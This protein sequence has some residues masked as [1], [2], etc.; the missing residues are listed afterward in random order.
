MRTV[1]YRDATIQLSRTY[2]DFHDYRDDPNNLPPTEV[3][4][5]A[6]LVRSAPIPSTFASRKEADDTFFRLMFPG[7]GLSM[8]QLHDPVALYS[9]EVPQTGEDRWVVLIEKN[10]RWVVVD[11]FLW[12]VSSGYLNQAT[13][14]NGRLTYFDRSGRMLREKK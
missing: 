12:P 14:E 7:Y 11:D 5:V 8:L 10:G 2:L 9:I 3:P 13:Y 6:Q 1:T 4:R